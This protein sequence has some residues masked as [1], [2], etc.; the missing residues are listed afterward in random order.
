MRNVLIL[1][2]GHGVNTPGKRGPVWPD[3][4]RAIEWFLNRTIVDGI[5]KRI[6]E[7]P[8]LSSKIT[9]Y[10]TNRSNNDLSLG[11]R[12]KAANHIIQQYTGIDSE[13]KSLLVSVHFNAAGSETANGWECWVSNN[14]SKN[15]K[16]TADLFYKNAQT[17]LADDMTIRTYNGSK[18][19]YWAAGFYILRNSV[20]PAVLT[21]NGF[22]TNYKDTK[23]ILSKEGQDKIVE[24][25]I[26]AIKEYFGI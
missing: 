23:F 17:I 12:V 2:A 20:C 6:L 15:S 11:E 21:E 18:Q 22:M 8:S 24:L 4:S 9:I 7:D 25:H 10:Q 13:F 26:Q 5:T 1:D 19:K 16:I 3:G 14:A